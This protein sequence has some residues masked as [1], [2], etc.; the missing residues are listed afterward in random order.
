MD[1]AIVACACM[2][3]SAS[4]E[5][6]M[7]PELVNFRIR[8]HTARVPIPPLRD[9]QLQGH[10]ICSLPQQHRLLCNSLNGFICNFSVCGQCSN[11][12]NN[13]TSASDLKDQKTAFLLSLFLSSIGAANFYIGRYDLGKQMVNN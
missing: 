4:K 8:M 7:Y 6:R 2:H 3:I 1:G 11:A 5:T 10:C 9:I 12:T 13:C